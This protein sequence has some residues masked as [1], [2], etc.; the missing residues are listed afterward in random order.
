MYICK[1]WC[2]YVVLVGK[3]QTR[4]TWPQASGPT[5]S[6]PRSAHPASCHVATVA[7]FH[8]KSNDQ[9]RIGAWLAPTAGPPVFS[10]SVSFFL[11]TRLPVTV[12]LPCVCVPA[13][14]G[15]FERE[16]FWK[17]GQN[18]TGRRLRE[19]RR[20][21]RQPIR[22]IGASASRRFLVLHA[23]LATNLQPLSPAACSSPATH[24]RTSV[25]FRRFG[26]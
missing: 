16:E 21:A 25:P 4:R 6:T 1:V 26:R 15:V 11:L 5:A 10:Q 2:F 22:L 14:P 19:C 12:V 20:G 24:P 18:F 7:T 17:T 3:R 8:S 9:S 23:P 13:P